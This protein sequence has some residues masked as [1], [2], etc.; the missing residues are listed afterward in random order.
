MTTARGCGHQFCQQ[1]DRG[2]KIPKWRINRWRRSVNRVFK[3]YFQRA[4]SGDE[5]EM[6]WSRASSTQV[7]DEAVFWSKTLRN[8]R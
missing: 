3:K 7:K 5:Q 4:H 1:T 6:R 2:T 8:R